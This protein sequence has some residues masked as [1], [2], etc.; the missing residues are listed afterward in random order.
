MCIRDRA[1]DE[2]GEKLGKRLEMSAITLSTGEENLFYGLDVEAWVKGGLIDNLIPYPCHADHSPEEIDMKYYASITRDS[3]CGLYP[4][5][6]PRQMPPEEFRRK[7]LAYYEAGADGL[8]FWDTNARHDT[9]SMW[10]TVRRLGHMDELKAWAME[11]KH[12]EEPRLI[13]LLKL[14]GYT[15]QRYLSLI[16]I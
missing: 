13:K 3:R 2:V 6:M 5:V 15:M 14:G 4:N 9:T 8:F 1:I 7:A 10:A 16:H 11:G 12:G